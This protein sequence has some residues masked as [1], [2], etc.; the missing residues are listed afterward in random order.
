MEAAVVRAVLV[1]AV[2]EIHRR[3][4]LFHIL[5]SSSTILLSE[6][7]LDRLF[8]LSDNFF[9]TN[10]YSSGLL[11]C[12]ITLTLVFLGGL[13]LWLATGF[14]ASL[15]SS[16]WSAWRFVTDGGEYGDEPAARIVGL[17]LVLSGM[18]F[19]ALLIGLI[20]ESIQVKLDGLKHGRNRVVE[21]GHTLVL[22]W[23]EHVLSLCEEI[24]KAN[25][26]EGGGVVVAVE[27]DGSE[28]I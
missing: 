15:A 24:A 6:E 20:G 11:L 16:M 22:G 5:S 27:R 25:E 18:L 17:V 19:F 9:A 10:P 1:I 8:Y 28:S 21:A 7:R 12:A 23:S 3:W 13:L 26:S 4:G 14:E 2:W